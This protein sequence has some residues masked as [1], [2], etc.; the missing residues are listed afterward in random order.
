MLRS[1]MTEKHVF[2]ALVYTHHPYHYNKTK[3]LK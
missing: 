2:F 3:A 1:I